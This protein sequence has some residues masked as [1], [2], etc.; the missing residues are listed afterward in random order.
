MRFAARLEAVVEGGKVEAIDGA[1][2]I[3]GADEVLLFIT[4]ATD[5][6]GFAGRRTLDPVAAS[7]ADI[8]A[9]ASQS[10]R[11][12]LSAHLA[13][14][15]R[16][17]DRCKLDL[18]EGPS[19][20][21][22]TDQR[23][24]AFAKGEADP[25]LAALYFAYGRYL[26][27]GSSRPG[28]LPANLQGLWAEELQT[29]WNSD[30]HLNINVQM[31]Y[32]PAEVT[33]LSEL[34]E[35][36]VAL[37]ESLVEPG[38]RTA[39]HYYDAPGWVAHTVTN[40]WGFT[41]PGESAHWGATLTCGIWLCEHLFDHYAFTGDRT[42]LARVWP[43][44]RG[45]AEF[46]L[47]ILVEEP[48]HGWLVTAPSNS[49]ENS[50]RLPDDHVVSLAL[51]PTMDMQL[52]RELFSNCIETCRVL[53]VDG[54]FSRKLEA[55][56]ARLAPNQIGKH[57]QLQE[58]LQDWEEVELQHRHTSH[59]YG[60]YPASEITP[61][62]TPELAEAAKVTLARRGDVGTGWSL[63]WK[64]A[65]WARLLDGD[66]ALRLLAQLL[67]PAGGGVDYAGNGSGTYPNLFCAHPPFQMDGN[68]GGSAAIAE[69]L[70][71]SH[72]GELHLLPAL[73]AAWPEGRV[74]GLRARG[75]FQVDLAWEEGRL[76]E[77]VV[78]STLGGR[79]VVRYGTTRQELATEPGGVYH[80]GPP[81]P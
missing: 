6:Q 51:G 42:Y 72:A 49:P 17:F 60:L 80:L 58:W 24:A 4:A 44:L 9:A 11:A 27:I 66:H 41:S 53:G 50:Y 32:W 2:S 25:A 69:L 34:V 63:A 1:L 23:L 71:Q 14:H 48:S 62:G 81:R 7:L 19:S 18:P 30:Y 54:D 65:F 76:T 68:F 37:T 74:K 28:G 22:P 12:L 67:R 61:E 39:R 52:L 45:A 47:A 16:W 40:V 55:A 57:G 73:P 43:V 33:G 56:R 36:L 8:E 13:D 31:N 78:R 3:R 70:L 10:W 35:P 64:V 26:L 79:C 46:A 5:Y 59:L 20:H 29:P 15:R 38:G 75:G 77:A 21:L